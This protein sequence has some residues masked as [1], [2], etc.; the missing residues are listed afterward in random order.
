MFP[1]EMLRSARHLSGVVR[2]LKG[3]VE[4]KEP[5]ASNLDLIHVANG[6]LDLSGEEIKLCPF[7][8]ELKIQKWD[9]D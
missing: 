7:S 8:P 3:Q 6:V 1:L 5:F 2:H 9:S 4:Q